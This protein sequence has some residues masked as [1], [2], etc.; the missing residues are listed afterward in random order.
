[1]S[2][3]RRIYA[4]LIDTAQT[5]LLAAS[6]FLVIYV[7]VF[8]PFQVN[9][10]SMSP[11]FLDREYVLTNLIILRFEDPR[12]G[13]V[14]VFKAPTDVEKDFI[15]RVIGVPND[16]V[17]IQGGRIFLNG[18][19]LDEK[20][21]LKDEVY[22]STGSFA[23]E[24][25]VVKVPQ[26]SYF[27]V[28]DNRANSSDSREWGFVKKSSIIGKSLFVYWPVTQARPVKNPFSN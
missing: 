17:V 1:M 5:L 2:I 12:R 24:G 18:V 13:D 19:L 4:F 6:V 25:Q 20:A 7:F 28:G 3:L 9:G 27:V 26:A 21:Y 14:I 23:K 11:N 10:A 15:K 22:T 16:T 8:R